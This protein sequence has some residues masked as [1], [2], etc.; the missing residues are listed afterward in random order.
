MTDLKVF[1]GWDSREQEA[2]QV[3]K[4]SV[5]KYSSVKVVPVIKQ[6][7]IDQG[8][9][10]R[11]EDTLASSEFTITRFLVPFLSGYKGFSLFMDCD[12]LCNVDITT[13][14]EGI[15]ERNAVSC[16]QHNY[17]P[18]TDVKMDGKVQT[19]Y[20]RKNWSSVML[21]NNSK[22]KILDPYTVN[23]ADPSWLHRFNW[24]LTSSIGSLDHTWN[25]LAGYYDDIENPN[26]IHYTDGGP[27]FEGYE[28][29][30]LAER[31]I[32]FYEENDIS[33]MFR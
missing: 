18:K 2:Y 28:N 27:W 5:E 29:C 8:I 26:V 19:N 23:R 17:T 3:A 11:G 13:I 1:I 10:Q 9:Y 31:W 21:F 6:D 15:N 16:V 20:P 7:L 32:K 33:S 12:I 30:P 22:C 4:A 14:L 24:T 25:Y